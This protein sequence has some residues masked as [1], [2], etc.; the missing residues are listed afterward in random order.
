M[1]QPLNARAVTTTVVL[2]VLASSLSFPSLAA[3]DGVETAG[4]V[5]AIA[6]PAS[7][8]LVAAAHDDGTGVVQLAKAY[9]SAMA[10]VYVLKPLVDRQR[11]D[12]GSQSFPSGHSASA[13]A[14]AAFLQMRYGWRYGVPAY[15]LA[16]FVAYSR[17]EAK[18]HW[19]SDVIVGG[20]IGVAS[21]MVFTRR[22]SKLCVQPEVVPG[23]AGLTLSIRW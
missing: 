9:A 11:P 2:L 5:A 22:W 7:G 19:T 13:F 10:V 15:A 1:R 4:N 17:V 6:L 14:G 21:N 20:A 23:G 8:L 18:R 16:G 3:A 12:G